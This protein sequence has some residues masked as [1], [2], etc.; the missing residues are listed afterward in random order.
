LKVSDP[1]DTIGRV[2]AQKLPDLPMAAM[3]GAQQ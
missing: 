1:L 3:T 2:R